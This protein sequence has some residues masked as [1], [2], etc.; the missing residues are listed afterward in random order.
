[1]PILASIPLLVIYP[2]FVGYTANSLAVQ[3]STKQSELRKLSRTDGL[4]GLY[5]QSCISPALGGGLDN[6]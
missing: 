3:L 4:T 2:L 6:G 1:M 5:N